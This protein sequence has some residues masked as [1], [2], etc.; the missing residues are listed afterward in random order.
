[1]AAARPRSAPG[2]RAAILAAARARFAAEGYERT[3]L[4]AVAGDVGVDPAMVIRYFG[5]KEALFAAAADLAPRLPDL[6]GLTPE[7]VPD[8]LLPHFFTVWED[9]GSFLALLRASVTSTTAAAAMREVFATRVA[10]ALSVVT[11]DHPL[12]RAN[13]VGA[14]VLG[15]ALDRYVIGTEPL[16]TMSR[17]ELSAWLAP[18]LRQ[19]LTGPAPAPYPPPPPP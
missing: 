11:P 5:C 13:L 2:T 15:T 4:R 18:T 19:L 7:Q 3:T 10:P 9:D 1:M 17:A 8:V 16:A 14:L 12:E 6:T